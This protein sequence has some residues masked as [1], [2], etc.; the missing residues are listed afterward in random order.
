MR[1]PV[2]LFTEKT[3]A[4]IQTEVR[5]AVTVNECFILGSPPHLK[6]LASNTIY[7]LQAKSRRDVILSKCVS[8]SVNVGKVSR[9]WLTVR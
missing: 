9:Y 7:C 3:G 5:Q 6:L 4:Q 1:S 2:S 8:K